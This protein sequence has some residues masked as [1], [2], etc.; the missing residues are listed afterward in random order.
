[1]GGDGA[2]GK[3]RPRRVGGWYRAMQLRAG[4]WLIGVISR[5]YESCIHQAFV[6]RRLSSMKNERVGR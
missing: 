3:G 1:M 4:G 6:V 2:G 5:W